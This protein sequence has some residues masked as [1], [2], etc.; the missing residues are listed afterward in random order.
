MNQ[1]YASIFWIAAGIILVLWVM[2]RRKR[3]LLR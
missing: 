3:K 1:T 2:R